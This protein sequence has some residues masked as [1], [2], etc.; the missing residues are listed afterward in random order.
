MHAAGGASQHAH[1]EH[2]PSKRG[3]PPRPGTGSGGLVRASKSSASDALNAVLLVVLYMIQGVPLGLSMGAMP[4]LLQN[5]PDMSYTK[6]GIFTLAGYPYSFKLLWSPIVDT[7][8]VPRIGLR[9]SWI[10]P[11]Q[12]LSGALMIS[13]GRW[14]ESVLYAHKDI[15]TATM[16]FFVLVLLAATQ[17]IAVDGWALSLLSKENVGYAA[18][19]QTIGMNI[20][21]FMSFTIFLALNDANFCSRWLGVDREIVTLGGYLFWWGWVYVGVTVVVGLFKREGPS[22]VDSSHVVD[23]SSAALHPRGD[24]KANNSGRPASLTGMTRRKLSNA[25]NGVGFGVEVD[26]PSTETSPDSIKGHTTSSATIRTAY[27]QLFRTIQLPPV[28]LLCA[29]LIV[30]RLAMLPA[31]SAS[32]LKLLEKGVSKEALAGLVLIEFPIELISALIAGKWA[33]SSHPLRPW[34]AGFKIRLL[35]A[36]LTTVC[37]YYF[38]VGVADIAGAPLAFSCLV[39]LGLLTSFSSTLMFTALG[40]FY[41]RI[42]DPSMGGAYLTMLNTVANIGVVVPKV[43]VFW[44]IDKATKTNTGWSGK[45]DIVRDGFYVVSFAANALGMLLLVGLGRV[46]RRLERYPTSAWRS[47]SSRAST[48]S[49]KR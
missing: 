27:S 4:F 34:L 36:F 21:Y 31:E 39:A 7:I 18:T 24:S 20:G 43:I 33:A 8:H 10:L 5:I 37:V 48:T 13:L 28:K 38:P 47:S 6:I 45:K 16:Y 22:K 49:F 2:S 9:K 26:A 40:D 15:E 23:I 44:L 32:A 3:L 17:D 1:L 11:L 42:S 30:S 35:M 46:V 14:V 29:L 41:N 19:C 25:E 12:L